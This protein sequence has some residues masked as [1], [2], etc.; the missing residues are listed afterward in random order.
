M[1]PMFF[2]PRS[3]RTA[4]QQT[5]A[6][7]PSRQWRPDE[8][9]VDSKGDPSKV[10]WTWFHRFSPLESPGEDGPVDMSFF[11]RFRQRCF[12]KD[13]KYIITHIN[14]YME[15]VKYWSNPYSMMLGAS[16]E[17]FPKWHKQHWC[18]WPH[19]R[20]DSCDTFGV[21]RK[22]KTNCEDSID[23]SP[24]FTNNHLLNFWTCRRWDPGSAFHQPKREENTNGSANN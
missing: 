17:G 24:P 8:C 4:C 5:E 22:I 19:R 18:A 3:C 10:G 15:L 16:R 23:L 2:A 13:D 7:F 6:S 12:W 9:S 21:F 14:I 11:P 1:S 20:G